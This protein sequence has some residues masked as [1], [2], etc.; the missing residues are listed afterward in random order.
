[1]KNEL[2]FN[3]RQRIS[4]DFALSESGQLASFIHNISVDIHRGDD[5]TGFIPKK[6]VFV[7]AVA[8]SLYCKPEREESFTI[9]QALC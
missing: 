2:I 3:S 7:M 9:F 8:H 5:G 4:R 1:M 6:G